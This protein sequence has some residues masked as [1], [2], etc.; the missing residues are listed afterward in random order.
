MTGSTPVQLS[1]G[2]SLNDEATFANY[3]ADQ[4]SGQAVEALKMLT[5]G[6]E[7]KNLLIWGAPGAGLT[8]LLQAVCHD[9]H[10]QHKTVQYLPLRDM[11]GFS[12]FDLCEGLEEFEYVCLDDIDHVCGLREWEQALF[13]LYNQLRDAGHALLIASH[14]SPPAL[15]VL[16]ADLKS[17]LLGSVRYH[18]TSLPDEGKQNALMMRARARGMEMPVD[19]AQFILNRTSR[20]TAELFDL[21]DRLDDE[22]MQRKRK[23]TIPFVKDVLGL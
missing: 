8:H 13:H 11:V 18:V 4:G 3:Y 23:L 20:D 22:S 1:L 16:L 14:T 17:R 9:V 21:L 12:A 15:P 7:D 6:G 10:T 19:V 5:A 2:I